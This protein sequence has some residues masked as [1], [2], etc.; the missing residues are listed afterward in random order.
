MSQTPRQGKFSWLKRFFSLI[1]FRLIPVLLLLAIGWSLLRVIT[2]FWTQYSQYSE[3]S[4]RQADY[5]S[6][7]TA[8]AAQADSSKRGIV[9]VDYQ[10]ATNTPLVTPT[11]LATEAPQATPI[12]LEPTRDTSQPATPVALPTFYTP[13]DRLVEFAAGTAVPTRVPVIP[14]DYELINILLLGGDDELTEDNTV[15]TDTMII[16]SINTETQSV[17]MLSLP[18]D[19]FV[20]TPVAP[21]MTRLNT[22]F[23]L[24]TGYSGGGFGLMRETVFYNFGIQLHYYAKV[25]FSNFKE[26]IDT[27]GGVDVAVSCPYQDYAL[28]DTDVPA[29]AVLADAE[30]LLWTLPIGYYHWSGAEALWYARTR[31]ITT[32]FDRG[33][34]QQQLLRAIFRAALN[35]GQLANVP[36]L[37][38]DV[39]AVVET[40]M[41]LDVVLGLVPIGLNLDPNEI[42]VFTM[43]RLYHT[44]PWQPTEGPFTGQAIQL[45]NYEPIHDLFSNFYQPPTSNRLQLSGPRIAVYNG[46]SHENWDLVASEVL[47]EQGLNAYAAGVADQQNL[48]TTS[49]IDFAADSRSNQVPIILEALNLTAQQ[50]SVQ[51]DPN[52]TVDYQVLVGEDYDSCS[53]IVLPVE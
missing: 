20:Y 9:L 37:W 38:N 29:G 49:V 5:A 42:Q 21:Y 28:I 16:V 23:G 40:D 45:L 4:A 18:R 36:N 48:A 8:I 6:T 1:A 7:A 31:K 24:G 27:L 50:V 52:R 33:P 2:V 32:D 10:F 12:P 47:R 44:T 35:N 22:V 34:R 39:K 13:R 11:P 3:I 43:N 51:P 30:A 41:P 46:T 17:S 25:N 26:I 14:R 53:P 15:R 19:L